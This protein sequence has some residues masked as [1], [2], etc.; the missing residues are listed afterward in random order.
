MKR[1]LL[2]FLV[3]TLIFSGYESNA[4]RRGQR[5]SISKFQGFRSHFDKSKQY[6]TIGIS[7][8][9]VNYF[10]DITPSSSALSTELSFTRPA[11]GIEYTRRL[12]P[13]YE[14]RGAFTFATIR[15][16]DFKSADP[17]DLDASARYVRNLSFRNQIK[18]L[19]VVAII[20]LFENNGTYITRST[21]N[22][23]LLAGIGVFLHNP[24]AKAPGGGDWVDLE[25]LGTEGQYSNLYNVDTY[26]KIGIS[27]PLGIGIRYKLN[28][29]FDIEFEIGYRH[30]FTDYLDDVSGDYVSPTAFD[31]PMARAMADRS[32]E[33]TSADGDARPQNLPQFT[34]TQTTVDGFT[35]INGYGSDPAIDFLQPDFPKEIRGN[36][37]NDDVFIF[38]GFHL[39]YILGTN[40]RRAKFR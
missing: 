3:V 31:D 6:Q 22:P 13:R 9:A 36:P 19:S 16:D 11:I 21:L 18:E 26:S 24:Q 39:K 17:G 33:T 20:E 8:S 30:T 29:N 32:R 10:G 37:D 4:Q 1:I 35:V 12:G 25:P 23:Y 5:G 34:R 15:G 27:I 14:I 40:Y 28:Q 2:A 38:T 7:I